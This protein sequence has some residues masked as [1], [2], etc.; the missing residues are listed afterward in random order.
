MMEYH[1]PVELSIILP[2]YNEGPAVV[3]AI[4]QYAACLPRLGITYELLVIDDGSRDDTRRLAEQAAQR[5]PGV[6]VLANPT[7]RGQ[8]ASILRGLAE[9]RGLVAMHNGVDLP[10][11]PSDTAGVLEYLRTGADIVV[12]Q[13]SNRRA[14]GWF[15]KAVSWCNIALVKLLLGSPFSDHNFVQA[16]RRPVLEKVAVESAGVSTVT[17]ELILKGMRL[18]FR[19]RAISADYQPRRHG[20]STITVRKIVRTFVELV[21]LWRI[22][23]CW[24][25]GH[26]GGPAA[27]CPRLPGSASS[28]GHRAA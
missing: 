25:P 6:R 3:E 2:A 7:N 28:A 4:E 8:V 17:P 9:C 13:R 15:R 27:V 5:H 23:R 10:F 20:Q 16:Y 14:Y 11:A 22:L 1:T 18:G 24:Q 12:V 26:P 19:V 21:K